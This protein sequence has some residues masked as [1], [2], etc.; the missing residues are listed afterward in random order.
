[1]AESAAKKVAEV[2]LQLAQARTDEADRRRDLAEAQAELAAVHRNALAASP[3]AAG[4]E[5]LDV[6]RL[7]PSGAERIPGFEVGQIQRA[8]DD[9]RGEADTVAPTQVTATQQG[10]AITDHEAKLLDDVLRGLMGGAADG[11]GSAPAD[12]ADARAD[13]AKRILD[14][15]D[16]KCKRARTE[17]RARRPTVEDDAADSRPRRDRSR[18]RD[19]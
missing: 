8:I 7:L 15:I 5:A 2:E 3:T 18:S 19:I 10:A 1:M 13:A 16:E 17:E 4:G 6:R 14:I 9:L 11:G 12:G